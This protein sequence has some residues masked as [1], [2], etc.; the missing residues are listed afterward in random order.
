MKTILWLAIL[1]SPQVAQAEPLE[2]SKIVALY[3]PKAG[4]I[5][6]GA[7]AK[8]IATTYLRQIYGAE[9]IRNESPF[10]AMLRDG[11]WTVEGSVPPGADGGAAIIRLC[12]RNGMVLSIIHEK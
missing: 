10:I 6:T 12:R 11:V 8:D 2:C 5:P 3:Q 1:A 7:V 4:V 9:Q